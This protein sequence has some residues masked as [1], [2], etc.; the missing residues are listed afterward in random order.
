[1]DDAWSE[2]HRALRPPNWRAKTA[3][4]LAGE[5]RYASPRRYDEATCSFV[6]FLVHRNRAGTDP[7]LSERLH[8][9]FAASAT[10]YEIHE[11]AGGGL[12]YTIEAQLLTERAME[13]IAL[14]AGVPAEVI[15][16]YADIYFDVRDRLNAPQFIVHEI[17]ERCRIRNPDEWRDGGWKCVAYTA[18]GSALDVAMGI[19][20]TGDRQQWLELLQ[21]QSQFIVHDKLR[22]LAL[23]ATGENQSALWKSV[24]LELATDKTRANDAPNAYEANI[25]A[26]FDALTF[27]VGKP[28]DAKAALGPYSDAAVELR[29]GELDRVARGETLENEAELLGLRMPEPRTPD[30]TF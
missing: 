7:R 1:M 5:R 25:Q 10:A 9:R 17:L 29:A 18:G 28:R 26:F 3:A 12:R 11:A 15:T 20:R 13:E 27:D 14:G 30:E 23:D 19:G 6:E 21:T 22:R 4:R 16:G 8:S 24:Q 2:K